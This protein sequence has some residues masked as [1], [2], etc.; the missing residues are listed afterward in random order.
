MGPKP[1][2][3]P[4]SSEATEPTQ[5]QEPVFLD[6]KTGKP[7]TGK[8]LKK[9]KRAAL[10]NQRQ[11]NNKSE[12]KP[13]T[14]PKNPALTQPIQNITTNRPS[15]PATAQPLKVPNPKNNQ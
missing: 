3:T 10:V 11:D 12:E 6:E 5:V 7:L 2:T 4:T 8:A 9:A 14:V 1:E 13:E 15:T